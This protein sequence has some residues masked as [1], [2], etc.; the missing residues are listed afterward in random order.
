M[1]GWM[2]EWMDGWMDEWM[3][4]WVGGREEGRQTCAVVQSECTISYNPPFSWILITCTTSSAP[5]LIFLL[6]SISLVSLFLSLLPHVH[7]NGTH[8]GRDSI[9]LNIHVLNGDI[10]C[11]GRS[12]CAE[13]CS[14]HTRLHGMSIYKLVIYFTIYL[15]FI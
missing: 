12:G 11:R 15:L 6:L 13:C 14:S 3:D 5:L 7:T 10:L 9:H 8:L 4:G 1:D 2:D